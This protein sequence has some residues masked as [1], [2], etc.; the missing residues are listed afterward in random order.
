M[1]HQLLAIYVL[2]AM[3][4]PTPSPFAYVFVISKSDILF[5]CSVMS[6]VIVAPSSGR[7]LTG[8][9]GLCC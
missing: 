9:D 4:K 6:V 5:R 1:K 7:M 3:L 2:L 8:V